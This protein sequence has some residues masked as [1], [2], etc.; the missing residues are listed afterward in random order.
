ME[1]FLRRKEGVIKALRNRGFDVEE[2]GHAA[3][4]ILGRNISVESVQRVYNEGRCYYDVMNKTWVRVKGNIAVVTKG[5][6]NRI[7]KTVLINREPS[8]PWNQIKSGR[9]TPR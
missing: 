5:K 4:R 9:W 2:G 3:T 7:L 1:N 8:Q 6:D